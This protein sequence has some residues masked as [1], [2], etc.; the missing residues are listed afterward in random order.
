MLC[1]AYLDDQ[2]REQAAAVGVQRCIQKHDI[3]DL[4]QLLRDF[5]GDAA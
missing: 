3:T 2:L 1:S 4:P 5:A